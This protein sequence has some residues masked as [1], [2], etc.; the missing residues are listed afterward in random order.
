MARTKKIKF[1]VFDQDGV[2]VLRDSL[3]DM[4]EFLGAREQSE[5]VT[6]D[7][8]A[9]KVDLA[10][11]IR[12]KE[13]I[14][15]QFPPEKVEESKQY[16]K[17]DPE[18]KETVAKLHQKGIKTMAITG[19]P[20]ITVEHTQKV[21]GIDFVAATNDH[22]ALEKEKKLIPL[23]SKLAELGI[24]PAETLA[25]GDS[26]SDE[27]MLNMAGVALV[28]RPKQGLEKKFTEIKSLLEIL[29]YLK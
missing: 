6:K 2:L 20:F 19:S 5:E 10:E 9:R 3:D 18:A 14:I 28:I 1:A 23:E 26:F 15:R 7:W 17:Y 13:E 12:R 16:I 22:M 8:H 25:V 29:D 4:A 11:A 21:L 24:S 27:A